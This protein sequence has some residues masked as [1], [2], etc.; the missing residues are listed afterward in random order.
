M[1]SKTKNWKGRGIKLRKN[2]W[3]GGKFAKKGK[4]SQ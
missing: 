2:K 4:K 3:G 1:D